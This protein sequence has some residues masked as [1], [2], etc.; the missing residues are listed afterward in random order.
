[1]HLSW[2]FWSLLTLGLLAPPAYDHQ[3]AIITATIISWIIGAFNGCIIAG[4]VLNNLPNKMANVS[5]TN[6]RIINSFSIL[7]KS[8]MSFE[9]LSIIYHLSI[10]KLRFVTVEFVVRPFISDMCDRYQP[11]SASDSEFNILLFL[12]SVSWRS[13]IIRF[14]H[15]ICSWL[16][17]A[18]RNEC[19]TFVG[20]LL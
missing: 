14:G 9:W 13:D 7:Q 11:I 8:Q 12:I 4:Y 2:S 6:M 1:M 5:A 17:F 10:I 3:M 15:F 20:W 19:W 16:Q 18:R